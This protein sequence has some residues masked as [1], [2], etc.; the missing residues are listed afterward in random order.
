[1]EDIYYFETFGRKIDA[2]LKDKRISFYCSFMHLE[3]IICNGDFYK[4][5]KSYIVNYN[6]IFKVDKD[7]IAFHDIN[8]IIIVSQNYKDSLINEI[9]N[10]LA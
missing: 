8:D 4:C 10:K 9:I 7:E 5:H 6:K 3:N 1:M 2:V